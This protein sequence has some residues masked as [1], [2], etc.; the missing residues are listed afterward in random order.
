MSLHILNFAMCPCSFAQVDVRSV[1]EV[2]DVGVQHSMDYHN[3][4]YLP[5]DNSFHGAHPAFS[6]GDHGNHHVQY[7]CKGHYFKQPANAE[8]QPSIKDEAEKAVIRGDAIALETILTSPEVR[9]RFVLLPPSGETLVEPFNSHRVFQ[10]YEIRALDVCG[11]EE[12][13]LPA[14][15][16]LR[17]TPV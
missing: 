14:Y 7:Q 13:H 4:P 11:G 12:L 10:R 8:K 6:G 3:I 16:S 1:A 2:P 15:P 17:E 9:T 5:H